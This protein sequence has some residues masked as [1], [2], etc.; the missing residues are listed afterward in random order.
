MTESADLHRSPRP[1]SSGDQ[2]TSN[3]NV[4]MVPLDGSGKDGRALAVAVALSQLSGAPLHLVHV[5]DEPV[6]RAH[7]SERGA[8][9]RAEERLAATAG[10]LSAD[11]QRGLTWTVLEGGDVA[12]ELMRHAATRDTLAVVM[13]TRAPNAI[14]RALVGSVADRIMRECGSPVS[15]VPPG[16]SYMTG[17]RIRFGR[18]LIPLD[19]SMLA[20]R[21][22]EFLLRLPG[23]TRLEYVLL[24][25]VPADSDAPIGG[26]VSTFAS[27]RRVAATERLE[28]AAALVRRRGA[29]TV[30]ILVT[31]ANDPSE[32]ITGAVR[33]C[34]VEMIAMSTR[35]AGGL[36]RL[37]LGSVAEAVVR[38][39]EVPVLLLTPASLARQ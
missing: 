10:R 3:R 6:D 4:V 26:P 16:A 29:T 32:A 39:S 21:A 25:V 28:S 9:A 11:A 14:E 27:S 30:E 22:L 35:G 37:V 2:A 1:R 8:R 38:A 23:A 15:L 33:D 17:K 24:E 31:E 36:R 20:A 7:E 19:G 12:A 34:L 18:V 13:G 5:I